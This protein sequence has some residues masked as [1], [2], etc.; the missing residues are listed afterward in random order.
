MEN[1]RFQVLTAVLLRTRVCWNATLCKMGDYFNFNTRTVH[2]L[3]FCTMINK[4]TIT[5]ISQ[6]ITLLHVSTLSCHP[7]GA[8]NQYLAKLHKYFKAVLV[9]QFTIKIFSHS[10]KWVF[11]F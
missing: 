4:C 5:G 8:Y 2:R 6:I 3:L 9:I 1:S 11:S 10:I 7:L